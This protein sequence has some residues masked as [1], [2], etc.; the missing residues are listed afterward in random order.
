MGIL[1]GLQRHFLLKR[2]FDIISDGEFSE[3]NQIFEAAI[4][5]LKWLGFGKVDYHIPRKI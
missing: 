3:S 2:E 4:A 5:E 1:F